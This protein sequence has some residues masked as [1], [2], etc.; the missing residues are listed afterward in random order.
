MFSQ[1]CQHFLWVK[2]QPV[3]LQ[4]SCQQNGKAN[5]GSEKTAI[6]FAVILL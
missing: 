1:T 5:G 4:E 2:A 6:I 3:G